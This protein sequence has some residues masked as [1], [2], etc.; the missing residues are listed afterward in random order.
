MR[1]IFNF[2]QFIN[3][4][5]AAG[6]MENTY[7]IPFKYS[8]HD[9][10][11]GYSSRSFVEDLKSIFI[12]KPEI[13]DEILEFLSKTMEIITIDDLSK[14]PFAHMIEIIPEIER[15][16]GAGEYQPE[17]RMPGGAILFIRNKELKT[18]KKADFYLN[19]HGTKIEVVTEDESGEEM[20]Y[21]FRTERFPF[22]RFGF[23]EKEKE[24]THSLI[25]DLRAN[26]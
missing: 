14:K 23:T 22:D 26:S 13:K 17:L 15:I 18:G 2:T 21:M 20:V 16:I 9:P 6:N 4:S 10:R 7:K 8:S 24:E 25:E 11:E 3:E 1:R 12:E 5:T 19:S